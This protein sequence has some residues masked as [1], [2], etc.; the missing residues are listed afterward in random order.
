MTPFLS[1]KQVEVAMHSGNFIPL[2]DP[3]GAEIKFEPL[4]GPHC[5]VTETSYQGLI[6]QTGKQVSEGVLHFS[7]VDSTFGLC[8]ALCEH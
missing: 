3:T 4:S 1:T 8:R 5:T 6:H 2:T 7:S